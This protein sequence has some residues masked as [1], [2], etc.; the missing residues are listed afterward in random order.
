M[1]KPLFVLQGEIKTPPISKIARIKIGYLF[2]Q[3]QDGE[4]LT[5]PDSRPMPIIG[6]NCHEL[7]VDDGVQ[8]TSWRVVYHIDNVAILVLVVF[9]KTSETTPESIKKLCKER[10]H[11]Y[12]T[13]M[14]GQK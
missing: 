5:M 12:L 14:K 8:K 9:K 6:M 13:A 11:R 3:L 1:S 2:R 4:L 10:L 7:R